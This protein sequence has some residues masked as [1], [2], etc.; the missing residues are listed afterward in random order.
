MMCIYMLFLSWL[1]SSFAWNQLA[2]KTKKEKKREV[3]IISYQTH[4]KG[5]NQGGYD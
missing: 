3:H 1:L 4:E 5:K 2:L